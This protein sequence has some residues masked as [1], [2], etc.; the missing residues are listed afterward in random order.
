MHCHIGGPQHEL[1]TSCTITAQV[2]SI[3]FIWANTNN[4][5]MSLFADIETGS[6]A[7]ND[8]NEWMYITI[9]LNCIQAECTCF[10]ILLLI[11]C[12]SLIGYYGCAR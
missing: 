2:C 4:I 5:N 1:L 12:I 9:I 6:K 8:D 11:T 7:Q 10:F 3:L